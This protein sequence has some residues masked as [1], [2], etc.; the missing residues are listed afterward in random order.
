MDQ[1]KS[2][3]KKQELTKHDSATAQTQRDDELQQ[4]GKIH[5]EPYPALTDPK[6]WTGKFPDTIKKENIIFNC[7]GKLP[8]LKDDKAKE[9]F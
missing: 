3:D 4:R 2:A 9:D 8:D 5:S 7:G 1:L 6:Y